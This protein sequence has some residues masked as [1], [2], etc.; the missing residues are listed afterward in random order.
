MQLSPVRKHH[1]VVNIKR[2]G[3]VCLANC[4]LSESVYKHH[5]GKDPARALG[6]P[7]DAPEAV[8]FVSLAGLTSTAGLART[9]S[10]SSQTL[11][12]THSFISKRIRK[13]IGF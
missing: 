9:P 3:E 6:R 4:N 10:S 1:S 8:P 11:S 5:V 7:A 12:S 13:L 2:P